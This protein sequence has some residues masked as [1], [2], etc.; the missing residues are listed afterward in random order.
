[1][2]GRI[3]TLLL[4]AAVTITLES[5]SHTHPVSW[6]ILDRTEIINGTLQHVQGSQNGRFAVS[7]QHV[8]RLMK[9]EEI[10]AVYKKTFVITTESKCSYPIVENKLGL[11]QK[12]HIYLTFHYEFI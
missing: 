7:K 9:C 12:E 3:R 5:Y 6:D 1:M 8:A 11:S 4:I 10:R 2:S